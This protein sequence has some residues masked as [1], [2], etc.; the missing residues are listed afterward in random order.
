MRVKFTIKLNRLS[1]DEL[2]D[3]FIYNGYRS[4]FRDHDFIF[5]FE[6]NRKDEVF[7]WGFIPNFEVDFIIIKNS[8]SN[9]SLQLFS[10]NILS[11]QNA[12]TELIEFISSLNDKIT[13]P[14]KSLV[15]FENHSKFPIITGRVKSNKLKDIFL[16]VSYSALKLIL[17]G[18][19]ALICILSLILFK[20]YSFP[21]LENENSYITFLLGVL[22]ILLFPFGVLVGFKIRKEL[23]SPTIIWGGNSNSLVIEE[24]KLALEKALKISLD[25]SVSRG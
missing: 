9:Y 2:K 14:E 22:L 23:Y 4:D 18:G 13:F 5:E 17:A 25:E 3:Y 19:I 10:K 1:A 11:L 7:L 21:M 24:K 20:F 8:D 6:D 12:T 15:F 16:M